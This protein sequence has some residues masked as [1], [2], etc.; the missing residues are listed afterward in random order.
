MEIQRFKNNKEGTKKA[1][2]RLFPKNRKQ[3]F[4]HLGNFF[5]N[6]FHFGRKIENYLAFQQFFFYTICG[7]PTYLVI[8]KLI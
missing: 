4:W 2:G 5:Q 8:S 3:C 7:F 1:F 6:H